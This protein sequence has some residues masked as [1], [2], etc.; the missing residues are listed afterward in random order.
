M[1]SS[2]SAAPGSGGFGP[3]SERPREAVDRDVEE[4]FVSRES[5]E[6]IYGWKESE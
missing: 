1:T 5:A 3:P 4:G 6:E 2:A